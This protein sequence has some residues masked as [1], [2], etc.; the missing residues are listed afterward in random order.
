MNRQLIL[1]WNKVVQWDDT[2]FILGDFCF[3]QRTRWEKILPQ[4]NG[5]KYLVLGNHKGKAPSK[6]WIINRDEVPEIKSFEEF[7]KKITE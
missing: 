5:L 6:Y 3:G 7:K 4:L 1:N 2:V